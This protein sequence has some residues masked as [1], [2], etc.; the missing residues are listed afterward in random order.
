MMI[1]LNP[2]ELF[3]FLIHFCFA[4]LFDLPNDAK[5]YGKVKKS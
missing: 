2:L 5:I 1:I 4:W 3:L